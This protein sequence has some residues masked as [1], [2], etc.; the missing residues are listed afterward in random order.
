MKILSSELNGSN[1]HM[2]IEQVV[3][4]VNGMNKPITIKMLQDDWSLEC[5]HVCEESH[6]SFY[7]YG[8]S[9]ELIN[10]AG[11]RSNRICQIK[12]IG[13][14][15]D[16]DFNDAS[17]YKSMVLNIPCDMRVDDLQMDRNEEEPVISWVNLVGEMW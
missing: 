8:I 10:V 7:Y 3:L 13:R 15:T 16:L 2:D 14:I 5:D 9:P 11:S 4:T 17:G 12:L 6:F 1:Y